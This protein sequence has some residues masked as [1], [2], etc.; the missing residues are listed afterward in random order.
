MYFHLQLGS[1]LLTEE[2][3]WRHRSWPLGQ[4]SWTHALIRGIIITLFIRTDIMLNMLIYS[5]STLVLRGLF[6]Y[7]WSNH[8]IAKISTNAAIKFKVIT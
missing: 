7:L 2:G 4:R 8:W 3:K 6:S 5:K 1:H